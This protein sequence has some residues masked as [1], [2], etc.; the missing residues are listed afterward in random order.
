MQPQQFEP[1]PQRV[2]TPTVEPTASLPGTTVATVPTVAPQVATTDQLIAQAKAHVYSFD[3]GIPELPKQHKVRDF[4]G[5]HKQTLAIAVVAFVLMS[6]GA[7]L[8]VAKLQPFTK[9]ADKTTIATTDNTKA[10]TS[11]GDTTSDNDNTDSSDTADDTAGADDEDTTDT[12]DNAESDDTGDDEGDTAAEEDSGEDDGTIVPD[13]GSEDVDTPDPTPVP[14]APVP[15]AS[16]KFTV[17]TWNANN[18]NAKN[19]GD[20]VLTIM[21]QTQVLGLQEVHDK[22]QRDRVNSKV[23][24]PTCK[25]SGYIPAYSAGGASQSSY[26]I[27]WNKSAFS[28]VGAGQWRKMCDAAKTYA[29]R[30]ATW[31]K[32]QSKVNGKQFY[33]IDTHLMGIGE[34]KGKPG[35]DSVLNAAYQTHMT[36][37]KNLIIDLKKDNIPIYV[38]GDFNVDYRYDKTVKTSYFPYMSMGGL[39]LKSNWEYTNLSGI[40]S[41]KGTTT[42]NNRLIDYVF[43]WQRSDVTSVST[44][45]STSTH[46]SDHY[47]VFFTSSVK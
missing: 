32:L 33:V 5:L 29:A 15:T 47:I 16:H 3:T 26:P 40:S 44:A 27:I 22:T 30:Y 14:T 36:N 13:D 28:I 43:A 25:Y 41:T 2:V 37:L 1:Q 34:S 19:V 45:L 12:G 31:V 42:A 38:A 18:D 20:E 35:S 21:G 9:N 17:A 23:I 6:S 7:A 10:S 46:G 11:A 8:A 39:L 4:V 24:C